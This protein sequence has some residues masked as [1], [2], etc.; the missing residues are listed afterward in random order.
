MAS[1][2]ERPLF[3]NN[4]SP[5]EL[6]DCRDVA[7]SRC[8][9]VFKPKK[10]YQQRS[11]SVYET[12]TLSLRRQWA[13]RSPYPQR[14][15]SIQKEEPR[16]RTSSLQAFVQ[17]VMFLAIHFIVLVVVLMSATVIFVH[18]EEQE[19]HVEKEDVIMRSKNIDMVVTND[20]RKSNE[21]S[22]SS[23]KKVAVDGSSPAAH[24]YSSYKYKKWFYFA[25]TTSLTIGRLYFYLH[26]SF[27]IHHKIDAYKFSYT[28]LL[29]NK[30][31]T[32]FFDGNLFNC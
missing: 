31:S 16:Y 4:S 2:L 22:S 28:L 29:L 18:L 24:A 1:T 30:V 21:S 5:A 14:S 27:R 32:Y 15:H 25:T 20:S 3:R 23:L 10:V 7:T 12:D 19:I 17:A 8:F 13:K 26:F 11:N 6:Q 9:G